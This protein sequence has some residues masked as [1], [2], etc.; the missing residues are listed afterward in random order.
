VVVV[1]GEH[2]NAGEVDDGG[3]WLGWCGISP[4]RARGVKLKWGIDDLVEYMTTGKIWAVVV[5]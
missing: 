2:L 3:R 5:D 4:E 1:A